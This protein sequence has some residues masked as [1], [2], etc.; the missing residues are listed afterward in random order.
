MLL[1]YS[2][3]PGPGSG[4]GA[5]RQTAAAHRHCQPTVAAVTQQALGCPSQFLPGECRPEL[6]SQP[7]T[8][9]PA[10]SGAAMRA[11]PTAALRQEGEGLPDTSQCATRTH[12]ATQGSPAPHSSYVVQYQPHPEPRACGGP[13]LAAHGGRRQQGDWDSLCRCCQ[14]EPYGARA[15]GTWSAGG[16]GDAAVSRGH[17]APT[18]RSGHGG[19][20]EGLEAG[21]AELADRPHAAQ[22]RLPRGRQRADGHRTAAA[23]PCSRGC[24]GCPRSS[25]SR[26]RRLWQREAPAAGAHAPAPANPA[27]CRHGGCWCSWAPAGGSKPLGGRRVGKFPTAPPA[28][29][30][31]PPASPG[32]WAPDGGVFLERFYPSVLEL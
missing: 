1:T 4:A 29:G 25:W 6:C 9:T 22:R 26:G 27:P 21:G 7:H 28:S 23:A 24:P 17:K 18:C 5:R 16:D 15:T 31:L 20:E 30:C 14:H 2:L 8:L 13:S 19:A 3:F 32:P 11:S 12:R 10:P